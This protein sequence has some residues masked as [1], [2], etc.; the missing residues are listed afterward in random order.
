MAVVE[1][2]VIPP[3]QGTV[4]HLTEGQ[5]L[6]IID[7]EGQQI[8]DMFAVFSDFSDHLSAR[9]SRAGSW[10]LFPPV[11]APFLSVN[12]RPMFVFEEDTSPGPHDLLAPPCSPEMY[13][14]LGVEGF[15][16]SCAGNFREAAD[17]IG[18]QPEFVPD[19]VDWFQNTPVDGEGVI[20]TH[21][22]LSRAGDSV[23][24]RALADM[25]VIVSAC[26]MDLPDK[27]INGDVCTS[28]GVEILE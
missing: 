14:L 6:R 5:G 10:R 22:A 4:L 2:R 21:T 11:G 16:R 1:S 7:R 8:A 12:Y 23:T 25:Y 9:T 18:W 27:L 26:A 15:H 13:A 24:L 28:I 3:Q 19:P 17:S 20:S